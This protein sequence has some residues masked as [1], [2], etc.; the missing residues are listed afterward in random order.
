MRKM[1]HVVVATDGN[2]RQ[3]D[4]YFSSQAPT[5]HQLYMLLLENATIRIVHFINGKNDHDLYRLDNGQVTSSKPNFFD[6]LNA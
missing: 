5:F 3:T 2:A 1:R 4:V 6:V